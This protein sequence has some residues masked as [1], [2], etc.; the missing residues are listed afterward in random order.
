MTEQLLKAGYQRLYREVPWHETLNQTV[1]IAQ[2]GNV[3][4]AQAVQTALG[5]GEIRV[6]STGILNSDVTVRIG[7]DWRFHL[8][9]TAPR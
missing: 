9:S 7:R 8:T 3:A 1:I 5:F 2:Q 6:D 4:A